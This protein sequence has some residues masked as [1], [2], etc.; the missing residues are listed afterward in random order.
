MYEPSVRAVREV[1]GQEFHGSGG[2]RPQDLRN[3]IQ[4]LVS[5][6]KTVRWVRVKCRIPALAQRCIEAKSL[7]L[8]YSITISP[9]QLIMSRRA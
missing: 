9:S 6:P 2:G 5:K 1:E 3:A 8:E 7:T 4:S